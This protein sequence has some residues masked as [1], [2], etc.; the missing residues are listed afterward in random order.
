MSFVNFEKIVRSSLE[1]LINFNIVFP[2]KYKFS[3]A[4]Q[5]YFNK[6]EKFIRIDL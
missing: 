4:T 3:L 2:R 6:N 5:I 1:F